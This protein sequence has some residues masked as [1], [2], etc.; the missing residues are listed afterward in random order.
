MGVGGRRPRLR[1]GGLQVFGERLRSRSKFSAPTM[2]L[3]EL[4]PPTRALAT[5]GDIDGVLEGN[6]VLIN[7]M[8]QIAG[9]QGDVGLAR[10]D[11]RVMLVEKMLQGSNLNL[12]K[13]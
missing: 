7:D 2:A 11:P 9:N 12:E 5:S 8:F 1:D 3:G 6:Q 10:V 4:D 13:N